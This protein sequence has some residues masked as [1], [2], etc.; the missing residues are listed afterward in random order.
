MIKFNSKKITI[1]SFI[2]AFISSLILL[3][4]T[5]STTVIGVEPDNSNYIDNIMGQ[6]EDAARTQLIANAMKQCVSQRLFIPTF[7]SYGYYMPRTAIADLQDDAVGTENNIFANGL[8]SMIVGPHVENKFVSDLSGKKDGKI[9]CR[10]ANKENVLVQAFAGALGIPP[11]EVICDKNGGSGLATGYNWKSDIAKILG[12]VTTQP[13]LL[14]AWDG[15]VEASSDCNDAEIYMGNPDALDYIRSLYENWQSTNPFAVSWDELENY[16]PPDTIE[17]IAA[18]YFL[19]KEDFEAACS[20]EGEGSGQYKIVTNKSSGSG[21]GE[22][23][24]FSSTQSINGYGDTFNTFSKGVVSCEEL[25]GL[26][27]QAAEQYHNKLKAILGQGCYDAFA[28]SSELKEWRQVVANESGYSYNSVEEAKDAIKQFEI[29]AADGNYDDFVEEDTTNGVM[30]CVEIGDLTFTPKDSEAEENKEEYD[31]IVYEDACVNSGSKLGWILC[32]IINGLQEVLNTLYENIV[33]PMLQINVSAFNT[34]NGVYSTWQIFQNIAN[35]IFVIVFLFAIFSQITGFGIDNYG[36]KRLLPKLIIA[37]I[38][39]N[40]SFII[41]QALVDVSNIVGNGVKDLLMS[42]NINGQP[43]QTNQA[44]NE[45]VKGQALTAAGGATA[46]GV[47]VLT[48][49]AWAPALLIPF[50]LGLLSVLIAIVFMFILLGIRQAGVIILVIISPLALLMYM[51][52]NTKSLFDKWKNLF[53]ALLV[54][55]PVCGLMIGGCALAGKVIISSAENFW[56]A[57]LG[58]LL[59]VIPFFLI[60]KITKG[61]MSA[62]GKIGGMIAGAGQKIGGA[63]QSAAKFGLNR[64]RLSKNLQ[65][66]YQLRERERERKRLTGVVNRINRN[67]ENMRTDKQKR[68]LAMAQSQLNRMTQEDA[69]SEAGIKALD[70]GQATST[71]VSRRFNNEVE[72]IKLQ[73]V[74]SGV[75]GKTGD[76]SDTDF[77]NGVQFADGTLAHAL[78]TADSE[79]A[80]YAAVNQLM[81]SGHHGEQAL[82]QVMQRLGEDGNSVALKS[83][84]KAAKGDRNFGGLKGASRSTYDYINSIANG[85]ILNG[86]G[87]SEGEQINNRVGSQTKFSNMSQEGLVSTN[88]EEL[89]R[90]LDAMRNREI[91]ATQAVALRNLATEALHNDRLAGKRKGDVETILKQIANNAPYTDLKISHNSQ[92]A[93]T[94]KLSTNTPMQP[95][96]SPLDTGALDRARGEDTIDANTTRQISGQSHLYD[97]IRDNNNNNSNNA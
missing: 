36:I 62:M 11:S 82:H 45:F 76:I 95:E 28:N 81:A 83:I 3:T 88:K 75:A 48:A 12:I 80:R 31:N 7:P 5:L 32:P 17:D 66:R 38:L 93:G 8:D 25:A 51:L 89:R 97:R 59:S 60:P 85:D 30:T 58:G 1:R 79:E 29:K 61:A 37:A 39:V 91:G 57:L 50:L 90:Y 16:Q 2:C 68:Q 55:Y 92:K 22:Y 96:N 34:N 20:V 94:E 47:A 73:N 9:W 56:M 21:Y 18:N 24:Y 23:T 13:G 19:Y 44:I 33:E 77:A 86:S 87:V 67:P 6:A 26:L 72:A 63:A 70:L 46:A 35:I 53:Q 15:T 27:T 41:C 74:N 84:S 64:S 42:V 14:Y 65:D 71:A 69:E 54:L 78:Y 49:G 43:V 52:P 4:T 40:L 10:E